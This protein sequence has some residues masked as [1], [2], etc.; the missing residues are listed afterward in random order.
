MRT[1]EASPTDSQAVQNAVTTAP[2][3]DPVMPERADLELADTP[4]PLP[5]PAWFPVATGAGR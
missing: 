1:I 2:G 4:P 3:L 5:P